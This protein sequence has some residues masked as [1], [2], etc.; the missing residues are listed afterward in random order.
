MSYNLYELINLNKFI[1]KFKYNLL[2]SDPWLQ[3]GSSCPQMG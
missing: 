3:D 1:I 2:K